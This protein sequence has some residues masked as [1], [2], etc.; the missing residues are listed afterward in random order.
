MWERF[1]YLKRQTLLSLYFERK[2]TLPVMTLTT[3]KNS[4]CLTYELFFQ[5][6]LKFQT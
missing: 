5:F 2:N 4:L 6:V 3:T 1:D